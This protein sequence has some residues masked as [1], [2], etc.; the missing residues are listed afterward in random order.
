MGGI[1]KSNLQYTMGFSIRLESK[2][3]NNIILYYNVYVFEKGEKGDLLK[4]KSRNN[5]T[6]IGRMDRCLLI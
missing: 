2:N 3:E 1:V 4:C 5:N 6:Q